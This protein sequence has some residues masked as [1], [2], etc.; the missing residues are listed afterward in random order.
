MIDYLVS[1][2]CNSPASTKM[3]TEISSVQAAILS[4]QLKEI[5]RNVDSDER[6]RGIH[7]P[8]KLIYHPREP[9]FVIKQV[10][11]HHL[12]CIQFCLT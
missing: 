9:F 4:S 12:L 8:I 3:I 2:S 5:L 1:F 11:S 7:K 10:R 6:F